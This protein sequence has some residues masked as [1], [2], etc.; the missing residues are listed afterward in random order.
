[1]LKRS[2]KPQ[3][4]ELRLASLP[5]IPKISIEDIRNKPE[6]DVARDLVEGLPDDCLVYHSYPWL[7]AERHDRGRKDTLRVGEADFVVVDHLGWH[8]QG[9]GSLYLGLPVASGRIADRPGE[10]LR[11]RWQF[12][13]DSRATFECRLDGNDDLVAR[14]TLAFGQAPPLAEVRPSRIGLFVRNADRCC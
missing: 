14:G 6:R 5:I 7:R 10:S 4:G 3:N 1:M 13:A 9:D 8:A 12:H 2:T 11:I